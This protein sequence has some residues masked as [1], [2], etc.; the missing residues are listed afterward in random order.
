[1]W[2]VR[3]WDEA[4]YC[5][6]FFFFFLFFFLRRR[7]IIIIIVVIVVVVPG[8]HHPVP[9]PRIV[10]VD[11]CFGGTALLLDEDPVAHDHRVGEDGGVVAGPGVVGCWVF[12]NGT[13][14]AAAIWQLCR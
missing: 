7:R 8:I 4:D 11:L 10:F 13:A 6:W 12:E 14:A 2:C 3:W 9:T 5:D 1:M